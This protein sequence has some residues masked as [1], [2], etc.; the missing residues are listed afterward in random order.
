M[1]RIFVL[2]AVVVMAACNSNEPTKTGSTADSVKPAAEVTMPAAIKSPYAIGYSSSFA[3]DDPKNA[4]T[5]LALWKDYDNGDL[6]AAKDMFADTVVFLLSDGTVLHGPKDS[7]IAVAQK[8]RDMSAKVVSRVNAIMALK[9]LDRNEH[10]A[11]IWGG[12]VDTDKKGKVDSSN[13]QETWRF[14]NDGKANLMFQYMQA[15]A[16]PKK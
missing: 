5:L 12:E 1:K 7:V 9:S 11:L 4:E 2:S 3:V 13:I 10:W 14:N 6:S 8:H 15:A 16:P